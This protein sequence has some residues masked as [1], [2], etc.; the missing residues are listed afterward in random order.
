MKNRKIIPLL[1]AAAIAPAALQAANSAS[2]R[3]NYEIVVDKDG[4]LRRSDNN[5]EVSFFGTNYTLPFA[6]AYR[7]TG[8]LG[9]DRK[10]IID[11]DVRQMKRLGFNGFRL[12]LWDAELA[13]SAGNLLSNEHL[14]LLDYLIAALER[15]GIDITL[16]G[17]TNFG[18]GYPERNIDTGA[19]TYDFDKCR[20]HDDP[21][22]QKAQERYLSQLVAHVNPYTGL[23]YA[24]D[25]AIIAFEIN[26]EP[27]HS[28]S[29]KQVTAY[30]NRMES[31]LRRAGFD[32]IV[33][34]NVSHNPGVTS[35]Y[36]D[37]RIQGSTYQ[38]YPDGLVA[39][40]LRRGNFLPVV[41]NY[42][43]PWKDSM[44][45][46]NR[47]ARFVYEFDP[48]DVLY[49]YL[50]PAIARTFRK[51]GFQWATQFAYDPTPLAAYNTEYQT[52]YVNLLYTPSKA[53]SLA[54]AAEAM[55]EI[56]SG[57]DYGRF[58][59]DTVFGP[60]TVS[61][62]RDL[63]ILNAPERFIHTRAVDV[64]PVDV[65]KL[66]HV[67]AVGSSPI[68]E[69]SGTGAYFLDRV[70]ESSGQQVWR[71]EVMPDATLY[72]DP[73]TKPSLRK[74]IGG[75]FYRENTMTLRLPG[76]GDEFSVVPLADDGSIMTDAPSVA[77]D[78]SFIVAPGV[79]LLGQ[80]L[81]ADDA[82]R[83]VGASPAD[84]AF[85][86]PKNL[87][88]PRKARPFL[89]HKPMSNAAPSD[90]IEIRA[91]WFGCCRPDSVVLYPSN[92][93]FWREDN[94]LVKLRQLPDALERPSNVYS[95][96]IP[97]SLT[98]NRNLTY[99]LVAFTHKGALTFPDDVEGTPLDWD[100]LDPKYYS[101]NLSESGEPIV[102]LNPAERDP[103]L[104]IS[105]VPEN[106]NLRL[107]YRQN[108]PVGADCY[109]IVSDMEADG[110]LLLRR[111]VGD[112]IN[113]RPGLSDMKNLT[114]AIAK[115]ANN[116]LDDVRDSG[117]YV[118]LYTTTGAAYAAPLY[119]A[120]AS[121]EGQYSI[122]LSEFTLSDSYVVPAPFPTFL[123]RILPKT[124]VSTPLSVSDIEF[125][126]LRLPGHQR[127][128]LEG[129]WLSR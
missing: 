20:I 122:L 126:E 48:G 68:A 3:Q 40:H 120:K 89:S 96:K 99:N 35:A 104:D 90:S 118:A 54:V 121:A 49:S 128:R 22:A 70:G 50:Y 71:L 74:K 63:S 11:M 105:S 7:A 33:L 52:H 58:P 77:A 112:D 114:L 37:A 73:F 125:V 31:A 21:A 124:E 5:A 56:P 91:E 46:Y 9:L 27:C 115:G 51:E 69:Y 78:G 12:H 108:D 1:L 2:S 88:A 95:V 85:C 81:V 18:N 93:S 34:Y 123:P 57:K 62:D 106:W 97:A 47:L 87:A 53:L 83:I 44:K 101:V 109:D 19:F 13:D 65:D 36:Y 116:D 59:T 127:L 80:S 119:G 111:Y 67:A 32:R 16:T 94:P 15:E 17:Q 129:V 8:Q 25:K 39:G 23:S 107:D 30:I 61:Y 45:N 98:G 24:K 28:G 102:L 38:W 10:A 103:M 60:F 84:Y 75:I 26:N 6:H 110:M 76:L 79:Y 92:V 66:R 42:D 86:A 64:A 82:A 4:L 29:K 14:D 41:D 100:A 113:G 117:V 43:I 55:R 72:S